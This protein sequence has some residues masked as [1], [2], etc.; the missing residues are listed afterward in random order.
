LRSNKHALAAIPSACILCPTGQSA[1]KKSPTIAK[2]KFIFHL[3]GYIRLYWLYLV[4]GTWTAVVGTMA[5]YRFHGSG[6]EPEGSQE[7]FSSR[8]P[9]KPALSSTQPPVQREKQPGHA[10]DH[11][12]PPSVQTVHAYTS[13]PPL[14]LD[15]MSQTELTMYLDTV[16]LLE[17]LR[18][19]GRLSRYRSLATG[20]MTGPVI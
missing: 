2:T 13:T 16:V 19:A 1:Q 14:C 17:S 11:T 6:F 4:R 3:E 15:N 8:Q 20:W 10:V 9:F 7:I 18:V 5:P 12:P